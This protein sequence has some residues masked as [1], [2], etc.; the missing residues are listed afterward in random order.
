MLTILPLHEVVRIRPD[1]S[2]GYELDVKEIDIDGTVLSKK[3]L[4][5]THLFLGA[6][7]MGTSELLVRARDRGDLP[8]LDLAVG[9]KWG[10]NSDILVALDNPI[11]LP[12]GTTQATIPGA[13]FRAPDKSGKHTLTM[14]N[15]LPFGFENLM[16][17]FI[18]MTESAEAGHFVYD[19]VTDTVELKW[20][21]EQSEP[22]VKSARFVFDKINRANGTRYHDGGMFGGPLLGDRAS[23]HPVGGCPLGEA[24]DDYGRIAPYP[25]LYV[26]DG[27]L[28]P[29]GL[30]ANPALTITALAERNIERILAED[31]A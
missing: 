2:G 6:G 29:I 20:A 27:S 8:D 12:T 4:A 22:A 26:V 21:P 24:T 13:T 5:C 7:S 31:F 23:Y 9:T 28:I 18:T 14:V 10:S 25:G 1:S 30:C 3:T 11:W 15:P 17:Y 16:T 19:R